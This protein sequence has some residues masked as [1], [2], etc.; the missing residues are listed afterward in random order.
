MQ[1]V[2]QADVVNVMRETFDQSRVFGALDS[3]SDVLAH[4]ASV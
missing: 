2:R 3:F 4:D 1:D